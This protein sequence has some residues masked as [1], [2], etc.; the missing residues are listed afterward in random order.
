M[1]SAATRDADVDAPDARTP[2]SAQVPRTLEAFRAEHGGL[3]VRRK[4]L[5][6]ALSIAKAG[7]PFRT[8]H[9]AVAAHEVF[10][11]DFGIGFYGTP[12]N[13]AVYS[14][15]SGTEGLVG[16]GWCEPCAPRTLRLTK[17]GEREARGVLCGELPALRTPVMPVAL[18]PEPPASAPAPAPRPAPERPRPRI[19]PV[20]RRPAAPAA[21]PPAPARALPEPPLTVQ[22]IKIV[23]RLTAMTVIDRME[24]GTPLDRGFALRTW[25]VV[26][27]A[28]EEQ[29]RAGAAATREAIEAAIALRESRP[30]EARPDLPPLGDCR[31]LL[32]A[33]ALF[34]ERVFRATG[35]LTSRSP[36]AK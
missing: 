5:L 24:R 25:D 28:T 8:E 21:P 16:A 4:L 1:T 6:V 20:A 29:V 31:R 22:Q 23:R 34:E 32:I 7:D 19:V 3:N 18:A 13:A 27:W 35:A 30:H 36:R 10:P 33:Q 2:A 26:A 15:I 17:E 9:L 14:R 11:D 12:D